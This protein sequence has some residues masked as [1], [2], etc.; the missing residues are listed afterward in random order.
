MLAA[1]ALLTAAPAFSRGEEAEPEPLRIGVVARA[2]RYRMLTPLVYWGPFTAKTAVFEPLVT[3]GAKG[4]T[5][6]AL[7]ESWEISPDGKTYTFHLRPGVIC[8]DG[9]ALDAVD[10][11]EHVRRWAANPGHEWL[12]S[13]SRIESVDA[14]GPLEVRV[15]LSSPWN[16][17]RDLQAINPGHV[18]APGSYD[19]EGVFKLGVGTGPFRILEHR[20]DDSYLLERH[21]RWWGDAAG[22]VLG[23]VIVGLVMA[24]WPRLS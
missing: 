15:R 10:V 12:G 2:G 4:E 13:T 20:P 1:A 16:L 7:A 11:R 3:C 8:H 9:T 17:L 21:E 19:N 18:V 5:V 24:L 6:P 23:A 14:P 22:L